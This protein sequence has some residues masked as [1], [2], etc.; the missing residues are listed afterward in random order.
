MKKIRKGKGNE[1]KSRSKKILQRKLKKKKSNE[2]T[3]ER[4]YQKG[5]CKRKKKRT[6][7]K[8]RKRNLIQ[9]NSFE[10]IKIDKKL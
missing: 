7:R 9:E 4:I 6:T 2:T 8:E 10:N 5:L 1:Q 3:D